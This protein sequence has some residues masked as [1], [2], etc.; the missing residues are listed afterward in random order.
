MILKV[1][2][3]FVVLTVTDRN[4]RVVVFIVEPGLHLLPDVDF[5][6]TDWKIFHMNTII[7]NIIINT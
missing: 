6:P 2:F 7:L 3:H 1:K 5:N 4:P